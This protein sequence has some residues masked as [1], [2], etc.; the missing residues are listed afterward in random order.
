MDFII[1]QGIYLNSMEVYMRKRIFRIISLL[2]VLA[3]LS[4]SAFVEAAKPKAKLNTKKISIQ[5][6]KSRKI[7]IRN[8]KKGAVYTLS[9]IHISGVVPFPLIKIRKQ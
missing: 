6:G 7:Q 8:R 4:Q 2:M 5:R 1:M 3:V 9:L